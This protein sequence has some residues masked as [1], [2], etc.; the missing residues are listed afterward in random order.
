MK[1]ICYRNTLLFIFVLL[2][3]ALDGKAQDRQF[4]TTYQSNVL[5]KGQRDLEIWTTY[6]NSGD[7]KLALLNR[8]EFE[9][10]LGKRL[11]ASLYLNQS[12]MRI[13]EHPTQV[14][15]LT[16]SFS[17]STELKYNVLTLGSS[18]VGIALYAEG[19]VSVE[20]YGW[21]SKLIMDWRSRHH[22]VAANFVVERELKLP[23]SPNAG[24]SSET[25]LEGVVGY[26]YLFSPSFGIGLEGTTERE[27]SLHD[28]KGESASE[29]VVGPSLYLARGTSFVIFHTY[30]SIGRREGVGVFSSRDI[31]VRLLIGVRL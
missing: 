31:F 1:S 7:G 29:F 11:Q 9:F 30:K 13:V 20:G 21:E 6:K 22:L 24:N 2:F 19:N 16:N 14:T 17:V 5:G 26:M 12:A 25:K 18:P 3:S 8:L 15:N 4:A 28:S 23:I 27:L 10:G